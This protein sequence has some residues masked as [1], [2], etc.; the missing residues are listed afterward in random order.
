MCRSA[1]GGGA[2]GILMSQRIRFSVTSLLP[3]K[4]RPRQE[5]AGSEATGMQGRSR[6][7]PVAEQARGY[8]GLPGLGRRGKARTSREGS[9]GGA[10]LSPLLLLPPG[11]Q[12]LHRAGSPAGGA[13]EA[14]WMHVWGSG[15]SSALRDLG[16]GRQASGE[17]GWP[18]KGGRGRQ[19]P[20][21]P[22]G[23]RSPYVVGDLESLLAALAPGLGPAPA[24]F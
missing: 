4:R 15:R 17:R 16:F 23:Q 19:S 12:A 11:P 9:G 21:C 5:A 3:E 1:A 13:T 2:G 10:D 20:L 7:Q 24:S 18:R 14:P 6:R 8:P 22:G